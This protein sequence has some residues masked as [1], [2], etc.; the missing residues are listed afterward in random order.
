MLMDA[1]RLTE[2]CDDWNRHLDIDASNRMVRNVALSGIESRNGYR[3]AAEALQQAV[4]LYAD[5][6]VFLDHAPDPARPRERSTRDLVGSIVNPRFEETRIRGDIKVLETDSGQ[7]FL[8]LIEAQTPGVGMSHVVLAERSRDGKRVDAIKDVISVDAVVNPATTTTFRE[9][10]DDRH[11]TSDGDA[12]LQAE[13]SALTTEREQLRQ[14]LAEL[15]DQ[16][17]QHEQQRAVETLLQESQLP[18]EAVSES[19][20][21]QLREASGEQLRRE[22][23]QDRQALLALRTVPPAPGAAQSQTRCASPQTPGDDEF[24]HLIRKR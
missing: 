16:L 23:I 14:E 4:A 3:Y 10:L 5:K 1:I 18:L 20:L 13:I 22:L 11:E 15:K 19:F 7:T 6:P 2:R 8:K 17:C 21:R 12:Q 9:S 24:V